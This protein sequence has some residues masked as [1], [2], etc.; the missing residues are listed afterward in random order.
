M[1]SAVVE[2]VVCVVVVVGGWLVDSLVGWLVG[3]LHGL[4]GFCRWWY[5]RWLVGLPGWF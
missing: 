3:W 4:V 5:G 1:R 2:G